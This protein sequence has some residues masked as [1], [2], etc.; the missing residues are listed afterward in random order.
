[1][2]LRLHPHRDIWQKWKLKAYGRALL[3]PGSL[4]RDVSAAC[5]PEH[6]GL[7]FA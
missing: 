7:V 1:M 2:L 5:A 6:C 3:S 4:I